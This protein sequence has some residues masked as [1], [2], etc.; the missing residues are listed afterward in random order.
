MNRNSAIKILKTLN[1]T[2]LSGE[3]VIVDFESGKYFIIQGVGGDIWS[4]LTN[5]ILV[6]TIISK[7]LAEYD[8]T[9]EICEREVFAFLEK[10]VTL[11]FIAVQ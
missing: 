9:E 4:M 2:D 7:L 3:K 8:V 11:G 1:V 6:E 5:G 10:L